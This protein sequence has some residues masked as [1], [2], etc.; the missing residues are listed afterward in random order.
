MNKMRK[1][2]P[3]LTADDPR[4]LPAERLRLESADVLASLSRHVRHKGSGVDA[5]LA[6]VVEILKLQPEDR[7]TFL[8]AKKALPTVVSEW[9]CSLS[10]PE[11]DMAI[12]ISQTTAIYDHMAG[13]REVFLLKP[14]PVMES[15]STHAAHRDDRS[16]FADENLHDLEAAGPRYVT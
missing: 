4:F 7:Q 5:F 11:R 1:R 13:L 8:T 15:R 14:I 10:R 9:L 16:L 12:L 6:F 3:A 2:V